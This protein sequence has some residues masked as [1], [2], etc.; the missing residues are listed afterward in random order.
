MDIP[1]LG[2]GR[3]LL[4]LLLLLRL[5]R[6]RARHLER[7]K[8]LVDRDALRGRALGAR[9]QAPEALRVL[10]LDHAEAR[11][12]AEVVEDARLGR[13]GIEPERRLAIRHAAGVEAVERPDA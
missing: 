13:A 3:R 4:L 12:V 9:H 7:R 10:L 6:A 2:R 8:L 11:L 5:G 1:P